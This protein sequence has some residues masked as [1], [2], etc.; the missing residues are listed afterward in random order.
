MN[1][2]SV[3]YVARL[4]RNPASAEV[5]ATARDLRAVSVGQDVRIIRPKST[6]AQRRDMAQLGR[7]QMEL[8]AANPAS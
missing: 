5:D 4:L 1:C 3:L 8:A 7:E 6:P 2:G